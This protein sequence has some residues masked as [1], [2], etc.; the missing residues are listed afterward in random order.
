MHCG[1]RQNP[2]FLADPQGSLQRDCSE[3]TAREIDE[4]VKKIL[5]DAYAAAK[6]ILTDHRDQLELVANEL[7]QKESLDAEAFNLLL[8]R[9]PPEVDGKPQ[10]STVGQPVVTVS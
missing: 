3:Q 9:K 4:E 7:L 10:P 8:G 2:F 5:D 6:Q 1:Q